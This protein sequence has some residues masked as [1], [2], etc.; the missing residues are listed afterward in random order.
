MRDDVERQLRE[1]G[2]NDAAVAECFAAVA[3]DPGPLDVADLLA[4][5]GRQESRRRPF[6][7]RESTAVDEQRRRDD[8]IDRELRRAFA[9]RRRTAAPGPHVDAEAAAAWMERRLDAPPR[10]SVEAHLAACADCQAMVAT[11]ARIT[12]ERA[13]RAG[14]LAG[15]RGC[16]ARG[17]CRPRRPR[18]RRS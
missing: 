16:A 2:L 10:S 13:S 12:P 4:A 18:R 8:A 1:A 5:G 7:R 14:G 3:A 17:S 11:L 9:R 6:K 15:G